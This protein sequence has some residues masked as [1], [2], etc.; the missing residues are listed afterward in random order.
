MKRFLV[1]IAFLMSYVSIG[2]TYNVST[3]GNHNDPFWL[4]SNV[5]V[6]SSFVV[7]PTFDPLTG[8]P[9]PQP[10]SNQV[11]I[12]NFSNNTGV[13]A[14]PID[15]GIVICTD[16]VTE[17]DPGDFGTKP[18]VLENPKDADLAGVWAQI[19]TPATTNMYD[20][21]EVF[22]SFVA[23][24]D[25]IRF[26]YVF[27]SREY[28][29]YTCT[30][31]NDVFGFFLEGKG[32]N[33][34]NPLGATVSVNLASIPGTSIP[35]AINTINGGAPTGGGT[36]ATCL[37]A[38][39]NYV[40]HS[41][42]YNGNPT[43]L[44]LTGVTKKFTAAAQVTCG[45]SYTI[46]L[47]IANAS[48]GAFDSAVFLEANSFT[49]PTIEIDNTLNSGNSFI[50][51]QI[52]EGCK[53]SYIS[54]K[55]NGNKNVDMTVRFN[56]AGNA[57]SGVDYA[58]LP[59]SLF[60]P[61][62]QLSDSLEILAY[63]DG[64]VEPNDSI[65]I[66]MQSLVTPCA[67]YPSQRKIIYL[68]DKNPVNSSAVNVT[69]SDTVYCPGDTVRLQAS[70]NGGEGILF[71]WWEDDTLAPL[72]RVVQP[73]QTTTYYFKATDEC[74][75]DTAIDSVTIY[76]IDYLPIVT[77]GDTIKICRGDTV[78]MLARYEDGKA[79]Y[80][81]VW[82]DGTLGD[83]KEAVP[84]QDSTWHVFYVTDA[85]GQLATD[86]VLVWMAP[87]PSAGFTY[88][89]DPGVP[90]KVNFTN[91]SINGVQ[92]TWDFGDGT[93]STDTM[94]SHTYDAP[95]E[96]LVTIT[97]ISAD[98]CVDSYTT[99]VKV[100][101]DFYLYVPTAFTPDGDGINENFDVK[102]LGFESYEIRIFNRWGGQVFY[103][104]DITISW[105]GKV[106]GSEAPE[107]VYTYTIFIQMPLGDFD[108]KKG[109]FTLY[110]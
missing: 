79:P 40:A 37:A 26:N 27:G 81:V 77:I 6:D 3:A 60:I 20:F 86:S 108:E 55:K 83:F 103:S 11:G 90:L 94:P 58:P 74:G 34:S 2:Q 92:Y 50:D 102:G 8:L 31:F 61:A 16:W 18:Q 66:D 1:S 12:F 64:I 52:V 4:V 69:G 98:G 10:S 110:R 104:D 49:S 62:G 19:G 44:A 107:G 109:T 39:P 57:I 30:Q 47:K 88:T 97:I 51:S 100:E 53:P 84:I 42:F 67:A 36:A 21:T 80:D 14:F 72:N 59:D 25:S 17:L 89:N 78:G 99:I 106:K 5:L 32:I 82:D 63:D 93:F 38:N 95:A 85:C 56:Y 43:Y 54:F 24:S 9:L 46:R 105:D 101:T 7:Y 41:V 28:A 23:T 75:S 33:G 13:N 73:Y 45:Q 48:D 65:I 29:N 35:V 22:F 87:D 91:T 96:Y 76:L 70:Y 71:G 68:R 15:S